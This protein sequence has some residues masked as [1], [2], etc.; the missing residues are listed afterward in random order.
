MPINSHVNNRP[1]TPNLSKIGPSPKTHFGGGG[2][3][4]EGK[5]NAKYHENRLITSMK[6]DTKIN[7]GVIRPGHN[8][9]RL[10]AYKNRKV[11]FNIIPLLLF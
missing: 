8:T 4:V 11:L 2:G 10:R 1:F 9:L 3:W 5:L 6:R 7:H